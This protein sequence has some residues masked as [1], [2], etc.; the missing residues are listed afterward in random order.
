[1]SQKRGFQLCKDFGG[2]GWLYAWFL[3]EKLWPAVLHYVQVF[4]EEGNF[5]YSSFKQ[6]LKISSAVLQLLS[7]EWITSKSE[8]F[9]FSMNSLF[10]FL[11]FL[12]LT[13]INCSL[14]KIASDLQAKQS[15]WCNKFSCFLIFL[16][17]NLKKN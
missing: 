16:F 8:S 14:L 6:F 3:N 4:E 17:T 15:L 11:L 1:M 13:S 2:G 5:T 7:Q 12:P 9:D 10:S